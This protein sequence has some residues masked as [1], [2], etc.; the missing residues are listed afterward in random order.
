MTEIT[1]DIHVHTFLSLCAN[2]GAAAAGYLE[3]C[4]SN[5]IKTIGFSDH[6]WDD[7]IDGA[8][9]WYKL[10]NLDHIS[11]IRETL[12][13]VSADTENVKILYG[14]ET[15]YVGNY[16][17][18]ISPEVAATLDF[19]LIPPNHFHMK[20]FV[21]P[22]SVN[23]NEEYKKYLIDR[24]REIC[25]INLGIPYVGIAHPFMPLGVPDA[26]DVLASITD[27]EY[28]ECFTY[29]KVHNKSIELQTALAVVNNAEYNRMIKIAYDCDSVF[30][31]G[32][33]AHDH[34]TFDGAHKALAG[35]LD[36]LG[37]P[38]VINETGFQY[39]KK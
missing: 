27:D 9:N 13:D 16:K 17:V 15:E 2:R 6:F 8:S 28:A 39:R 38:L 10:Q 14:C 32:S 25:E 18:G 31:V 23:T 19:V 37:M 11:A 12:A 26:D 29:A 5:N 36:G 34:K 30:H 24:F 3:L 33:D 22:S 4:K 20:D 1:S 7:K 21:I 35:F